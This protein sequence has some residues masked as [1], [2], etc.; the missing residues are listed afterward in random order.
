MKYPFRFDQTRFRWRQSQWFRSL[1]WQPWQIGCF[2]GVCLVFAGL[3]LSGSRLRS[4]ALLMVPHTAS[5]P[6]PTTFGRT[7]ERYAD[8]QQ[9][10]QLPITGTAVIHGQQIGLEI[11]KTLNQQAIGLMF[12]TELPPNRGMLFPFSPARPVAFWMK[13]TLIPL[14]MVFLHQGKVQAI[15]AKVPPC[16]QDPCP[17]YGPEVDVDQV[18]ELGSGRAAELGL[19]EGDVIMITE[20]PEA[21]VPDQSA[22]DPSLSIPSP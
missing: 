3:G 7:P 20:Y 13:N 10:Q 11:A 5:P 9:G 17:S 15:I 2:L 19:R 1:G 12:R 18:L 8:A 21:T 14:D 22:P 16:Q 4:Q 6:S